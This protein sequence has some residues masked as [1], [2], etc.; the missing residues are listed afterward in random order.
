MNDTGMVMSEVG[1][2]ATRAVETLAEF[3]RL[4]EGEVL[5]GYFDGFHDVPMP[6]ESRS[7]AYWH[8][9]RNGQVDNGNRPADMAQQA[10][11]R[12]FEM[13]QDRRPCGSGGDGAPWWTRT[14]DP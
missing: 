11:A 10:L 3:M 8:G 1:A 13:L 14:T 6:P 12:D 7:V 5:E 2:V 4:D 9:W